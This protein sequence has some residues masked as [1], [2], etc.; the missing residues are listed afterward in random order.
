[1]LNNKTKGMSSEF[2]REGFY[3][4]LPD[5]VEKGGYFPEKIRFI[6][7][8]ILHNSSVLDIGC[9]DGYIGSLLIHEKKCSVTGIDIVPSVLEQAKQKGIKTFCANIEK[10]NLPIDSGKFDAVL[11]SDIIEHVF[12]TDHL[13]QE[14]NRVLKKDGIL[15]I[16][17]PNIASLGRRLML[18]LGISPYLEYS[19]HLSTNGFPSVGHIRYYTLSVLVHQLEQYGFC[20]KEITGD[21]L[22]FGSFKFGFAARI[23]PSFCRQILCVAKKI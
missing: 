4:R 3:E 6:V 8:S 14:S 16:S 19:P 18:L 7:D 9:N 10:G 21:T 17:T 15:V 11:L 22:V 1:M 5:T 12:D 2:G 20:V 13:L 23:F